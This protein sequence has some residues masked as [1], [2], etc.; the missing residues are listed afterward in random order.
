MTPQLVLSASWYDHA[1]V[2]PEGPQE[3][4][5]AVVEDVKTPEEWIKH[6]A[7]V[8]DVDPKLAVAIAKAESNLIPDAKNT[9][10]TASGIFQFLNSTAR[11]YCVDGFKI[12]TDITEKNDPKKQA[13][14]AVR[15]LSDGGLNH[16]S[17]SRKGWQWALK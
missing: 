17:E 16:W 10:S 3:T 11:H 1:L 8:Y 13:E 6:Y 9:A 4:I 5:L 14:C 12:M 7:G 2:G 15:M